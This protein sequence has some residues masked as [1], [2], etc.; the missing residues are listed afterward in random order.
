VSSVS[1]ASS[2]IGSQMLI[3]WIAAVTSVTWHERVPLHLAQVEAASIAARK[4]ITKR[5][6]LMNASPVHSRGLVVSA[7]WKGMLQ[8]TAP[9]S[10]Q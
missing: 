9:P 6:V 4:V 3:S 2:I 10:H 5:S 1:S 7:K 8:K